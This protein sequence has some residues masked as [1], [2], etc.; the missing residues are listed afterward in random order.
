MQLH[1]INEPIEIWRTRLIADTHT[2]EVSRMNELPDP[3][4][5]PDAVYTSIRTYFRTL[6]NPQYLLIEKHI[7]RLRDSLLIEQCSF[8][9]NQRF[10]KQSIAEV[11]QKSN[12]S[13][14]LRIKVVIAPKRP[15]ELLIIA[16]PLKIPSQDAYVDGVSVLTT[17]YERK[18]PKAKVF[19]F[20][21]VQ[22]Q[23]R[24]QFNEVVEEVIL[25]S[26]TGE[27]LE[28][29]SSN[30]FAIVD[31][32]IYT[33]GKGVLRGVTRQIVINVAKKAD[34]PVIYHR[35]N[36]TQVKAFEEC[37]ITSTSR[38]ILPVTSID[39]KTI[40]PGI[41]GPITNQLRRL[42]ENEILKLVKPL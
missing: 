29:L 25:L 14:E 9:L 2:I 19:E 36:L 16:E 35:V 28:G 6:E 20:V 11:V 40:G 23:I 8:V 32:N 38:G 34:I 4:A 31:G 21:E 17:H 24:K 22:D 33:T 42:F 5:M 7:Q 30:F 3:A 37:F 26:P 10:L 1:S 18:N 12:F 27:I 13:G 39:H 15:E 41:P